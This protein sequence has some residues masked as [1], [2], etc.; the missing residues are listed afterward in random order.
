MNEG[1]TLIGLDVHKRSIVVAVRQSG[2][3]G[4]QEERLPDERSAVARWARRW[5][6]RSDGKLVCAYEAGACGYALQRQL[7]SLGI[8]WQVVVAPSLVPRK[9]GRADQDES[10]RCPEAG[11]V[12]GGREPHRSTPADTSVG[13]GSVPGTRGRESGPDAVLAPALEVPAAA[14]DQ[15]QRGTEGVDPGPSHLG[16]VG[17]PSTSRRS[18][19]SSTTTAW[20]SL[21]TTLGSRRWVG[22]LR[23]WPRR[24]RM[25]LPGE[26]QAGRAPIDTTAP[27]HRSRGLVGAGAMSLR[28]QRL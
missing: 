23:H 12:S 21:R 27:Q 26:P 1:T 18:R 8:V 9:P 6:H 24:R 10:P 11:G 13:G 25:K 17:S 4:I 3:D 7:G 22:R 14:R 5:K 19:Q 2:I 20:P 16:W 28:D 15:L